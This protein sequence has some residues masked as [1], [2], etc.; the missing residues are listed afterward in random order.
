MHGSDGYLADAAAWAGEG[1]ALIADLP[2][3]RSAVHKY[4]LLI[5]NM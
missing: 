1:P 4:P 3:C 2:L 5:K